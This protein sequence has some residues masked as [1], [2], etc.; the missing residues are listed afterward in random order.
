[1][2]VDR[3]KIHTIEIVVDR[4]VLKKEMRS[5][6]ADSVEMALRYGEG[7]LIVN[8]GEKDQLFSQKS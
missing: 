4:I 5:R 1:M 2:K 3:Y 8:D 6:I 7:V